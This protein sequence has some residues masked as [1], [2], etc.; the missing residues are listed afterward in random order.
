MRCV[1]F[2]EPGWRR[3]RRG[4]ARARPFRAWTQE[5][6][7]TAAE[8]AGREQLQATADV[9]SKSDSLRQE[10]WHAVFESLFTFSEGSK[11]ARWSHVSGCHFR[12]VKRWGYVEE[13]RSRSFQKP[14]TRPL[15]AFC[16]HMFGTKSCMHRVVTAKVKMNIP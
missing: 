13:C 14:A 4:V 10:A 11:A 2:P 9:N 1:P 3:R 8:V 15:S 6:S 16:A 12:R 5:T 7:W